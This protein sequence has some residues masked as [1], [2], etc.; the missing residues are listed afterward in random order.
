[1]VDGYTELYRNTRR[2]KTY[3]SRRVKT[4]GIEADSK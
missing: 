2:Q 3:A 4:P 1:M